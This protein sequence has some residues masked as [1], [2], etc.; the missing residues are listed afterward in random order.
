MNKKQA[1]AEAKRRWGDKAE[2][3]RD[4]DRYTVGWKVGDVG[5]SVE[6]QG[7]TWEEAFG[8]ADELARHRPEL[9]ERVRAALRIM[10][11]DDVT[12]AEAGWVRDV[13]RDQAGFDGRLRELVAHI[14]DVCEWGRRHHGDTPGLDGLAAFADVQ[15]R[16]LAA[17]LATFPPVPPS[18]LFCPKPLPEAGRD[19]I[20]SRSARA[21]G[22]AGRWRR[23]C[24]TPRP[25]P[26]RRR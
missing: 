1:V 5:F 17:F 22:S 20:P 4:G 15:E 14:R 25:G 2:V 24:G 12:D 21:S 19:A 16:R 11:G 6:G 10:R 9:L 7:A 3:R 23:T 13:L 26:R 8:A 18:C